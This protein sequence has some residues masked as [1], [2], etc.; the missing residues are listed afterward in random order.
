MKDY[1]LDRILLPAFRLFM[2]YNY[3]KVSTSLLEKETGLTRGAIFYKLKTKE[4]IFK[5]VVDKFV[6]EV[7]SSNAVE[8]I[9]LR[10][11][12]DNYVERIKTRMNKLLDMNID[13]MH[14]AY[15]N[16]I[17]QAIQYYPGFD[18]RIIAIFDESLKKWEAIIRM[19]KENGEIKPTCDVEALAQKF[20]YTY[21]GMSFECSLMNGLDVEK[22]KA[23]Y[24]SYYN[25][26]KYEK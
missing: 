17:Y 15:F 10:E 13:N 12:I 25:E 3:E 18:R 20:R 24:N 1:N 14:R 22:L 11:Y 9:S 2:T 5:A 23:L 6:L 26:I 8:S 4:D 16:L 19:A 21:S 7:Q